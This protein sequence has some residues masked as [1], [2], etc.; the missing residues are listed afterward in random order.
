MSL[1]HQNT[2]GAVHQKNKCKFK[3]KKLW[4]NA[5][6]NAFTF[7]IRNSLYDRIKQLF[8]AAKMQTP[9]KEEFFLSTLISEPTLELHKQE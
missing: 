4:K 5:Y 2:L 9:A 8:L 3:T 6:I 7:L 1:T